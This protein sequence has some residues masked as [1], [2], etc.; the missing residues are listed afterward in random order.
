MKRL[1][2]LTK[3]LRAYAAFYLLLGVSGICASAPALQMHV[4]ENESTVLPMPVDNTVN[5]KELTP[6]RKHNLQMHVFDPVSS[7]PAPAHSTQNAARVVAQRDEKPIF[8][9]LTAES[10]INTGYRRDDL[11]WSIAGPGNTP[12]VLSELKWRD[13]EI[14]TLNIGSTLY[15]QSNWLVNLDLVY[16]RVFDGKNQDSD[17]FGNNKTLEFSRSNNDADK[18]DVLDISAAFGYR[19]QLPLDQQHAYPA[20]EL[21]PQ[22]GL[23][24]HSQNLKIV[25][26][27][28]TIPATG[29]FSGLDTNY[30]ATWFG[31]WLGLDS[32]MKFSN[33]FSVALNIEYHYIDY[34]ATANWNLRSDFAHPESFTHEAKG[35]GFVGSLSSQLRLNNTLSLNLSV[36]YQDWQADR[37]GVDKTFFANGTSS[38][39]K[40]NGVNWRS[41]GA[42]LGL[43][44]EF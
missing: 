18:G 2:G 9:Y 37:D 28:Q 38:T 41:F 34:D 13:I 21:R 19:W 15:L 25:D 10:Y 1:L 39:T 3:M 4:F 31:P 35:Y 8:A 17:Y 20:I 44:Y 40:F 27:F 5:N 6:T 23:S 43:I 29:S 12:N 26:G 22:A 42:N 24:Y 16:G 11:D 30:D 14:A 7:P 33:D 36:D 32:R